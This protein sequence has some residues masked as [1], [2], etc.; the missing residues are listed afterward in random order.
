MHMRRNEKQITDLLE[1]ELIIAK[2]NIL[3]LAMVDGVDPYV[4]PLNFGYAKGVFYVHGAAEGRK[5][6]VLRCNSRVCFA[7]HAPAEL[8]SAKTPC[9]YG[10]IFESVIGFGQAE[11][12]VDQDE[13]FK[14]LRGIFRQANVNPEHI[15]DFS[16]EHL[17][18]TAVLRIT[19]R[20]MT[21]KRST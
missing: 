10:M 1:I 3:H 17:A 6:E 15:A 2:A 9:A 5:I 7:L 14:A 11:I 16:A 4:V 18:Q 20:S 21:G 19:V 8:K 12:V 13:K